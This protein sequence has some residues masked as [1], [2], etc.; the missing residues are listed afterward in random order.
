MVFPI[1]KSAYLT[2]LILHNRREVKMV[3][4]KR[5]SKPAVVRDEAR[6]FN[7]SGL[8]PAHALSRLAEKHGDDAP[9]ADTYGRWMREGKKDG[10]WRDWKKS[11]NLP[12]TMSPKRDAQ[13]SFIDDA[14]LH[15][16]FVAARKS[17]VEHSSSSTEEAHLRAVLWDVHWLYEP[18]AEVLTALRKSLRP[19]IKEYRANPGQFSS[20][21]SVEENHFLDTILKEDDE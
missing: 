5:R 19:Y 14:V 21:P 2:A 3:S 12:A 11:S 6:Y 7:N 18:G 10:S 15:F 20:L 4:K 16:S 13:V 9:S 8:S 17:V 1:L